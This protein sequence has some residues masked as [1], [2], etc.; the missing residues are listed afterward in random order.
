MADSPVIS[1]LGEGAKKPALRLSQ[2]PDALGALRTRLGQRTELRALEVVRQRVWSRDVEERIEQA[3]AI[4][5]EA[6][7]PLNSLGLVIKAL[8]ALDQRAPDYLKHLVSY[9]DTLL[10]LEEQP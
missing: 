6:A 2:T 5:P 4:L 10:W 1:L 8:L 7:G 3:L 9:L